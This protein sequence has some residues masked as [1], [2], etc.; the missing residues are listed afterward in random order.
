MLTDWLPGV[1]CLIGKRATTCPK[2]HAAV[3]RDGSVPRSISKI[4]RTAKVLSTLGGCL[5]LAAIVQ[6]E[7]GR[8]TNLGRAGDLC[9]LRLLADGNFGFNNRFP[10]FSH[11]LAHFSGLMLPTAHRVGDLCSISAHAYWMLVPC[12]H[13]DVVANSGLPGHADV[14]AAECS[15][16]A[17]FGL[18]GFCIE[19]KLPLLGNTTE[20]VCADYD[21]SVLVLDSGVRSDGMARFE[22]ILDFYLLLFTFIYFYLFIWN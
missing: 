12:L 6:T 9:Q 11:I 5:A 20:Y 13:S 19:A 3:P 8:T 15:G 14:P 10:P 18:F 7:W 22:G 1:G 21:Q 4:R 16:R 17:K 2:Y